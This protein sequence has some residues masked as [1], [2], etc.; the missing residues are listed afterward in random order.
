MWCRYLLLALASL[1][2]LCDT[3]IPSASMVRV[4]SNSESFDSTERV[5][6]TSFAPGSLG[7]DWLSFRLLMKLKEF[8]AIQ[9]CLSART[10]PH[11][12]LFLVF[13][14]TLYSLVSA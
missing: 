11:M 3:F 14:L 7:R 6:P 2:K 13:L 10:L 4:S 5:K 1:L 8:V 12:F 9:N